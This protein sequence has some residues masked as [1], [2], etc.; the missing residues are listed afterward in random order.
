MLPK[1]NYYEILGVPR[2]ATTEQIK[3]RYRQLV[4]RYH[5]DVA[6]DKTAAQKI[7]L[8]INEAYQTLVDPNKRVIYD[9]SLD[10][11][12]FSRHPNYRVQSESSTFD[13]KQGGITG[14]EASTSK[15]AEAQ[16][17]VQE[18]Q[19]A[20]IRGQFYSAISACKEARRLDPQNIW[21]YVILGDIYRIQNKVDDAIAM[22][23]IAVQLDPDNSEIQ[24]K[25]G[26]LLRTHRSG[27]PMTAERRAALKMG[28]NLMGGSIGLFLLLLLAINPGQPITWIQNHLPFLGQWTTMLVAVLAMIGGLTGFLLSVNEAVGALDEE[29]VFQVVWSP[30]KSISYPVG[31]LIIIFNAFSFYLAAFM[32]IV[33]GMLQECL[34]ASV[35]KAFLST[36]VLVVLA[37]LAYPVDSLSVLLFGGNIVLPAMLFGWAIGDMFRPGW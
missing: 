31:L 1:R 3:R 33:I 27:M 4:R 8:E 32:Y 22:Y 11:E 34:S 17:L 2:N 6:E 21:A 28:L 26:R 30:V 15:V 16:R 20:F 7:F 9:A 5:P 19:M 24:S 37:S 12:A 29:L 23:T 18:A 35:L 36:F 14:R 25:L 13:Y 10:M